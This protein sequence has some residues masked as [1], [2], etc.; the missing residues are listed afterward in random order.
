MRMWQRVS[1]RMLAVALPALGLL[2]GTGPAWSAEKAI[3]PGPP[4]GLVGLS[5]RVVV[6]LGCLFPPIDLMHG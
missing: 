2:L 1:R 6:W 3:Q 4:G 5:S